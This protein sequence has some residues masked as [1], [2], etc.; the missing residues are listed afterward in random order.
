M[1]HQG[2]PLVSVVIPSLNQGRFIEETICSVLA[3]S[4]P[5]IELIVVDGGSTDETLDVLMKYG[6]AI[7]WISEPDGGHADAVNKGFRLAKGEIIGWLNS[8]DVYFFKDTVKAAVRAFNEF[9]FADIIYGDSVKISEKNT[10]LRMYLT[11]PYNKERMGRANYITQPAVFM[12]RHVINI[13]TL[14]NYLSLDYEFW[15]RLAKKG[16]TF[17]HIP[18]VI[19]GDR[20]YRA[21]ASMQKRALIKAEMKEYQALYHPAQKYRPLRNFADSF[22]RAFCRLKGFR[23]ILNMMITKDY[24]DRLA[25]P[26]KVDSFSKLMYRQAFKSIVEV[27]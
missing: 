18:T 16:Y 22:L 20:Q 14:S 6:D 19:A 1:T 15:L 4:Y 10:I 26:G 8:D 9:T 17:H 25:F 11:L 3:Q 5:H 13:E 21:R 12:R 2:E 7:Q 24:F 27:L 23:S